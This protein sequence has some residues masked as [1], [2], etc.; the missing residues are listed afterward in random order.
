M[1]LAA[2]SLLLIGKMLQIV[3]KNNGK[4]LQ[5]VIRNDRKMSHKLLNRAGKMLQY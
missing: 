1:C 3:L 2:H 4:M 5:I